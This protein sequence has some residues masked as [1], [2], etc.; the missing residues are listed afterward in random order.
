MLEFVAALLLLTPVFRSLALGFT[1]LVSVVLISAPLGGG[2]VELYPANRL[3]PA[4][5]RERQGRLAVASLAQVFDLDV[6]VD[7]CVSSSHNIRDPTCM[8]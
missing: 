3:P 4:V 5:W 2:D 1:P 6:P 7:S 8:Y